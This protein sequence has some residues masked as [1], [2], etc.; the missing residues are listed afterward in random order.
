M[1]ESSQRLDRLEMDHRHKLNLDAALSPNVGIAYGQATSRLLR[2]H[3][4][5]V[6]YVEIPFELLQHSPSVVDISRLKPIILHCA[7]LSVAGSVDPPEGTM[8]AI[9]EWI[10]RTN[11]PWLGEHLSFITAEKE[12]AGP[13]A[14]EY[15][16]NEPYNLG[17]TVSPPF[18][19]ATMQFVLRSIERATR[20]FDVPILLENSPIYF[21]IPASTMTQIE[22]ISEL[23]RRANV[24]LLLDLAHFYISS[25]TMKFDSMS[26]VQ[27]LPLDRV[28]E[29]H[30]SGV[31]V[32]A[33]GHW[34]NHARRAPEI[35]FDLLSAVL[36]LAP[37]KA[38]TLE[39]NW[40]GRFPLAVLLE[41][42][43]RTRA[44]ISKAAVVDGRR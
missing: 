23:C 17:Y 43:A 15:A 12:T 8:T 42:L 25:Q 44:V 29:I 26:E 24:G 37:V 16:P 34:D 38:I 33:G 10:H 22:F 1:A 36:P 31:D 30:I 2:D 35:E 11:T 21:P 7:S 39:Y 14:D 28:V 4:S 6:D 41:E 20:R 18:N 13:F 19:E 27:S 5:A 40:S 9:G 32:E 3:P